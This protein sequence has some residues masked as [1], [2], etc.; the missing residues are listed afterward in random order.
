MML[1][2]LIFVGFFAAL[3]VA[4]LATIEGRAAEV[5]SLENSLGAAVAITRL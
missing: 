4:G 3:G 5:T 2:G 1:K